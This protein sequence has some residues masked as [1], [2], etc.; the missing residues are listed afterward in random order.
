ML[1]MLFE[2]GEALAQ[3]TGVAIQV[4]AIADSTGA[5]YVQ[6]RAMLGNL[7]DWK[8]PTRPLGQLTDAH[9]TWSLTDF[10]AQADCL[11]EL[12]P[13]N[14]QT[15]Q[16]SLDRIRWALNL[17]R[18]VVTGNKGPLALAYGDLVKKAQEA[19]LKL[20]FSAALL[21]GLPVLD[22]AKGFE[23]EEITGFEGVL[24]ATPNYILSRMEADGLDFQAALNLSRA[25][26][27]VERDARLDIEGWDT[28]A[29]TVILANR[30][31]GADLTMSQVQ[32]RGITDVTPLDLTLARR[33]GGV[34]KLVGWAKKQNGRVFAQVE[35]KVMPAEHP[36]SRVS[37]ASQAV[38]LE[39]PGIGRV[40]LS[41]SASTPH[42][43][44]AAVLR[45]L[46]RLGQELAASAPVHKRAEGS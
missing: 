40:T 34:L 38:C 27:I 3:R 2:Q 15:A 12:G 23:P 13:T 4:T 41:G 21:G 39:S 43:A 18:H 19:D 25:L 29:K 44:A 37:G 30:L 42:V 36:L 16:P 11:V 45:D 6:D 17:G 10:L 35:P 14:L 22:T 28:A 24:G 46:I 32:V 8:S 26:G 5:V 33:Q 31:L 7:L 20:Y 1:R 9:P